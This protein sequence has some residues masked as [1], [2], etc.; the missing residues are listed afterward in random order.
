MNH[1]RNCLYLIA[2]ASV[3]SVVSSHAQ[4]ATA[5][6]APMRYTESTEWPTYGHDSGGMRFSPLKQITPANVDALEIAWVYHLKPEGYVAPTRAGRAGAAGR[7]GAPGRGEGAGGRGAAT[8]FNSSEG[9]SL[10]VGGLMYVASPYGRVVA[11]NPTTGKEAWAYQLPSGNPSTRGVE[12]FPG[13]AQMPPLIVV[14]TSDAKLFTLDA[15]TGALNTKFGDN[16]FVTLDKSPT[17]PSIVYKNLIIIGGRLGEGSGPGRPGDVVAYDIHDGKVAWTF[18]SIPQ[19]GEPNFGSWHGDSANQ[20]TGVNVWGFM[21]VDVQR[22][23]VYM[24]FGAAS[25]DLFGGDRPGDNL[26]SSSLVAADAS[27]GKYL[28]HFQVVHHD[29]FDFD[30]ESAPVLMDVKQGGRTIPAVAVVGKSAILFLLDRVTGK[31]IYRVEERPVAQSD[32]PGEKMSPTQPFPVK[33]LP[34]ARVNFTMADIAT[35][36]PELEANCKKLIADNNIDVGKGPYAPTTYNRSRVI[37]PSEI[38]GPNWGGMSFNPA[39]G[40]LFVNVNDIGQLNGN[41]DPETGPVDVGTLAGSNLPGGRTGPY[42]NVTPGGRFRDP[43]T[44]LFCN[45]PPWGELVAINVHTGDIAWKAPLGVTD[46]LPEDRQKTGRPN[47]G[48]SIATAGGLVFIG[49]TDDSRFRAFDAKTG[50]ELW[51]AK[52]NASSAAVPSTYQGADGR[53]YVVVTAT[54]PYGGAQT[55]DEIVAFALKK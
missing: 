46:T 43:A 50:K 41:K 36:T 52:L 30:L 53:Q 13:D 40:Y 8:G 9:T 39:L 22:G 7:G 19:K 51:V 31:P 5:P 17:S 24:P 34:V 16:G 25:S 28:W 29:V 15:K 55:A 35:V 54:G 33:P 27:T 48:G 1:A 49:A 26:Y 6:V 18:H 42:A 14:G 20:R 37:F 45:Q 4:K 2:A 44:G 21:T 11:L 3:V 23:I 38:G 47:I 10:I 32:V 12:Y